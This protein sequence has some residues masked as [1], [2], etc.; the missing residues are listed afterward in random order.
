MIETFALLWKNPYVRAV[1]YGLGLWL[2]YGLLV[3]L[4]P[5]WTS[6][7]FA[8]TLAYLAH[9]LVTRL[10]RRGLPR[11]VGV[12]LSM[13][14]LT[15]L[16]GGVSL[17]IS[18]VVTELAALAADV[19]A[20]V[21]RLQ[22]L[23]ERVSLVVSPGLND[24]LV[25]EIGDVE[26]PLE[27]L[28]QAT[29]TWLRA[30]SRELVR[31]VA[32]LIGGLFQ[33]LVVLVLTVYLLYRFRDF[34]KTFLEAF[35]PRHQAFVRELT[36][37]VDMVVGGYLRAQLLIALFV[38]VSVW[39]GL[40][41]LR[42]PLAAALGALAGVANIIPLLGPV[43]AGVPAVLLALTKGWS[44]ALATLALLVVINQ[45][46][47]NLLSPWL[48]ARTTRVHPVTVILAIA[49]GLTLFGLWGALLA[50]PVAALLKLLYQDY[51]KRS[52]WY[53]EGERTEEPSP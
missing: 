9:P 46:D 23:P 10:E 31:G 28:G 41:L 30:H 14:M 51:Y 42:V 43:I 8:Y 53:W 12:L 21:T 2:L 1:V 36:K 47:G 29:A 15:I 48:F 25:E 17:L 5:V 38:G 11:W 6:L 24:V 13:L 39:L 19:P 16:L 7:L 45:I 32:S 27:V 4:R 52:R 22:T 3:R 49:S 34:S 37:R 18:R 40:A 33:L 50:V 20:F 26:E 44:Y 35:P